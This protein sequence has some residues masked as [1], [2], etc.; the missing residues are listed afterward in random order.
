[1]ITHIRARH[2]EFSPFVCSWPGCG[3]SW[4]DSWDLSNHLRVHT[5]EKPFQC[6]KKRS[7]CPWPGC[8]K[9]FA[10]TSSLRRHYLVHT[11]EKMFTCALCPYS[12]N[13]KNNLDRHVFSLH[14]DK[15][16]FMCSW[17]GC[18]K[19]FRD[20]WKLKR[21]W[22]VHTGERAFPCPYWC[23][24]MF[25]VL[26]KL[27]RH[28]PVHTGERAFP[29]PYCSY[30]ANRRFSRSVHLKRH[31]TT[32]TGEKPFQC[33]VCPHTWFSASADLRRHMATH[34]GE[35][36]YKCPVCPHSSNRKDNM[37]VHIKMKHR[38]DFNLPI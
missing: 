18:G 24:K 11:G 37:D 2:P 12:S 31:M 5:G 21:H 20:Q 14:R 29:C 16:P 6:P 1:M 7:E 19:I 4:R 35:K 15:R 32:H 36:P 25:P 34:T 22:P 9:L 27:K 23:G 30:A 28:W 8:G 3:K 26:S 38:P 33:P 17:E 10:G 13:Q